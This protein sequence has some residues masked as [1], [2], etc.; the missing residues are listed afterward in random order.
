[1]GY[2]QGTKNFVLTY[3]RSYDLVVIGYFDSNFMS[4]TNNKK[5]T[6]G[7][8]IM[9]ARRVVS[10]KNAK[11]LITATFTI[12]AKCVACCETTCETIW[13]GNK[14]YRFKVIESIFKT[15]TIY[16]NN[17]VVVSFFSK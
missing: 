10:W 17:V 9:M 11:Q 2:L 16:C 5:L 4:Y 15:L 8:I 7:C 3:H 14:I 6:F 1:M 12:E 13:L